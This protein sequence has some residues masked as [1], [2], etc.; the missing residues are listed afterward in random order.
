LDPFFFLGCSS[1]T[2]S[3][4]G[5]ALGFFQLQRVQRQSSVVLVDIRQFGQTEK[6]LSTLHFQIP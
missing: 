6:K 4:Y 5:F 1:G 3:T 2:K